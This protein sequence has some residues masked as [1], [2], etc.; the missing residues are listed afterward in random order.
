MSRRHIAALAV[1]ATLGIALTPGL[2]NAQTT[3]APHVI[4]YAGKVAPAPV[5]RHNSI[6]KLTSS[7][8]T[9]T[10]SS[11]STGAR[12]FSLDATGST[13]TS[14]TINGYTFDFGDGTSPVSSTTGT[15]TYTY[16]QAGTYTVTVTVTDAAGNTATDTLAVT[17]TGSDYTP[18]GPVRLLDTRKGVGGPTAKIGSDSAIKLQ[19]SGVGSIPTGIT[20]VVITL[21]AVNGTSTGDIVAYADGATRP[22]TSNVN[23]GANEAIA[24]MATVPVGADGAI[25]L[26]NFSTGTTDLIADI[27]GYF[28][29]TAASGFTPLTPDRILNT[30]TTVGG[31]NSPI[32]A[33]SSI[34]LTVAGA[35]GGALPSSG[36]TAVALNFTAVDETATSGNIIAYADGA[37]RPSTSNLNFVATQNIADY[38]VVPVGADGKIDIYNSSTGT[39]NLIADVSGYFSAGGTSSYVPIAPIRSLDTRTGIDS[40]ICANCDGQDTSLSSTANN[41]TAYAITVTATTTLAAGD[42]IIYA[43]GSPIPATSNLNWATEQTLA[44]ADY[45]IPSSTGIYMRNQT[46]STINEIVDEFGYY[47]NK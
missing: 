32:P 9:A 22:S 35:D 28:A 25:D 7:G 23:F 44:N 33:D 42:M 29:P 41:A 17:T 46:V 15:T 18:Y 30:R 37:T 47:S 11:T 21:T 20:A 38:A 31:H 40:T 45:A 26:Y 2:A 3:T 19:I 10:L 43:A 27:S 6:G 36:I 12:S 13:D 14:S 16:A 24:A 4:K 1:G 39:I 34:A 5:E 8:L